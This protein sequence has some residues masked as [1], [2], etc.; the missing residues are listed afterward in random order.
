MVESEG[1]RE[2]GRTASTEELN[3]F[4]DDGVSEVCE[5]EQVFATL[6]KCVET[7]LIPYLVCHR[8]R[9]LNDLGQAS[10]ARVAFALRSQRL[11]M[12]LNHKRMVRV[13][14]KALDVMSVFVL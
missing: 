6:V 14:A 8:R 2:P 9:I 3:A 4:A 1:S 10:V 5:N 7:D 13:H 12:V 11:G